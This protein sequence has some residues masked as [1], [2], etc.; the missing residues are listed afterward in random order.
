TDSALPAPAVSL[1]HPLKEVNL[2]AT[3][4]TRIRS[5]SFFCLYPVLLLQVKNAN[6]KANC[7]LIL[8]KINRK[9]IVKIRLIRTTASFKAQPQP[10]IGSPREKI[11]AH[12]KSL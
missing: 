9:L 1:S 5:E 2:S 12:F 6:T 7:G 10:I 8:A 4:H 3:T 11:V